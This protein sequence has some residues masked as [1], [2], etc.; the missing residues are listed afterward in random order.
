MGDPRIMTPPYSKC[1]LVMWNCPVWTQELSSF[2]PLWINPHCLIPWSSRNSVPK[3][4]ETRV[5]EFYLKG[6][7]N[8]IIFVDR[9]KAELATSPAIFSPELVQMASGEKATPMTFK[10]KTFSHVHG[11]RKL[12]IWAQ[13]DLEPWSVDWSTE[14]VDNWNPFSKKKWLWLCVLTWTPERAAQQKTPGANQLGWDLLDRI[15]KIWGGCRV[16]GRSTWKRVA[17]I[18]ELWRP[19]E[20]VTEQSGAWWSLTLRFSLCGSY[21]C[22]V[23][24]EHNT[25]QGH[26]VSDGLLSICP[27]SLLT[28]FQQELDLPH[29]SYHNDWHQGSP[30][31]P[32]P[33]P[34]P[35]GHRPSWAAADQLIIP[36]A[37]YPFV[38]SGLWSIQDVTQAKVTR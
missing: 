29:H 21:P 8:C 10:K 18:H 3:G 19:V 32:P 11:T 30:G 35:R 7:Q 13:A 26:I 23:C 16:I 17:A 20:E 31:A 6:P 25:A 12:Q 4:H 9:S 22:H 28:C 2:T 34:N 1:P 15:R 14:L 38:W 5:E 33:T 24:D 27:L 37:K 36:Y